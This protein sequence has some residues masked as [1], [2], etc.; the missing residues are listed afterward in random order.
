MTVETFEL[1]D[2]NDWSNAPDWVKDCIGHG[3]V[4]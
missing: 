4:Y 1:E 2:E 3:T